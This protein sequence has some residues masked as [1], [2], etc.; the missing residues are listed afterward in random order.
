[1]SASSEKKLHDM[2]SFFFTQPVFCFVHILL[3]RRN[4]FNLITR[5]EMQPVSEIHVRIDMAK[6]T[7]IRSLGANCRHIF[8]V[9]YHMLLIISSQIY[10][11]LVF[12]VFLLLHSL[13]GA[14]T[15]QCLISREYLLEI[16]LVVFAV[17]HSVVI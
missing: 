11:N 9:I 1:M 8:C 10:H 7:R 5:I 16:I 14:M 15:I 12:L 3:V 2:V 13:C 6:V 4:I 17:L